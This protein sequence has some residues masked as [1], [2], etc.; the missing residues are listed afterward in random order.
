MPRLCQ[1]KH[2]GRP[3]ASG[4]AAD[5]NGVGSASKQ[6]VMSASAA[7]AP[8]SPPPS[9]PAPSLPLPPGLGSTPR[10]SMHDFAMSMCDRPSEMSTPSCAAARCTT[11]DR[12]PPLRPSALW[13][14]SQRPASV[15]RLSAPRE[16][17]PRF[18]GSAEVV[19]LRHPGAEAGGSSSSSRDIQRSGL[20][21][22][23]A[24]QLETGLRCADLQPI[25]LRTNVLASPR[26][27]RGVRIEQFSHYT[28]KRLLRFPLSGL[29]S[30]Y[31]APAALCP[32]PTPPACVRPR[33]TAP[34]ITDV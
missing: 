10:T 12:L 21:R 24:R 4:L 14:M 15:V 11:S 5:Q 3:F 30:H 23:A 8:P 2:L 25:S 34:C 13:R 32:C 6:R 27:T 17:P 31:S 18:V 9:P 1:S 19:V 20:G 26:A 33:R 28:G 7:L 16:L 22:A 29:Q